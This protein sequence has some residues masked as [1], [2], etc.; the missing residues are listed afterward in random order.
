MKPESVYLLDSDVFIATKNAYYAFDI[1]PGFW[2]ALLE[3][4]A[5]NNIFSISRVRGELLAGRETEDLFKWVKELVPR[6]F[7]LDVDDEPVSRKYTEVMLWSQRHAQYSDQ[8]KA[9]FATGA[10]GWLVAYAAVHGCI[11]VT[12]ETPDPQS[13]RGIKLPDVAASF[14]VQTIHTFE[15]LRTLN[16]AFTLPSP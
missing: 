1:C 14:N 5:K 13:R 10:D 7:F 8:A 3:Q 4:H 2:S 6:T 12:N 16:V 11:I 9:K 15:L